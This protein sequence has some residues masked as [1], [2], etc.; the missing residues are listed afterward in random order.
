M[1]C[2]GSD[3]NHIVALSLSNNYLVGSLPTE[4]SMLSQLTYVPLAM[5]R[6]A[7]S[8]VAVIQ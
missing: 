8:L 5:S 4:I 2:S 1:T 3:P 7:L 6:G